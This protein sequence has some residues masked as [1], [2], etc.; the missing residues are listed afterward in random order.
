MKIKTSGNCKS[1][2]YQMEENSSRVPRPKGC[3]IAMPQSRLK[4]A[5]IVKMIHPQV[6]FVGAF[7]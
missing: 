7:K 5:T 4:S 3:T 2:E 6:K 1:A